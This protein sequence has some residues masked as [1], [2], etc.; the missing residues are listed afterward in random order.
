MK[1]NQWLILLVALGLMAGTA[2]ALAHLKASQ[3][4]GRPGIKAT[5][6]PGS[7]RMQI[8]LPARVLDFS[9]T[10]VPEPDVVLGYLPKD[11]S[12][13]QRHYW[14][15]DGFE[16]SGTVILMGEDRTSIHRPE[17][18]LLGQ[19]W[20]VY[21]K[22]RVEIP[23]TG[24]PSY[25]L[26]VMKWVIGKTYQT[27]D[28]RTGKIH[29]LYVFWF[30]ADREQATGNVQIQLEMMR[31][32]LCR[33]VLQRWSYISYFTLC[34]PGREDA[35]FARLKQLIGASAAAYLIPPPNGKW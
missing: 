15:P 14:A 26:P 6:I 27:P 3:K 4:L 10:N 16:A 28:G 31:D 8:N 35:A 32:L 24:N 9:S 23:V 22:T 33:G 29:G 20:T 34:E 18:C 2:A 11:T 7:V 17:Y 1:K 30:V 12:Y 25:E 13:I 21:S 5:P 19:G